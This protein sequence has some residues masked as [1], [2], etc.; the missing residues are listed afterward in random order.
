MVREGFGLNTPQALFAAY[1]VGRAEIAAAPFPDNDIPRA[2]AYM[3]RFYGLVKAVHRETFDVERAARLE[4][5]WWVVHRRVFGLADNQSLVDALV[6]LY[7]A[8]FAVP[9]S[10]VREAA[11]RRA[12]AMRCS[13]RWVN[14]GR[15]A[16]SPLLGQVEEELLMSYTALRAVFENSPTGVPAASAAR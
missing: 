2:E 13:D 7:A 14:D 11:F 4:V 5:N 6:D 1:L 15:R 8:T 9:P 10:V 16:G 3:R 12:E